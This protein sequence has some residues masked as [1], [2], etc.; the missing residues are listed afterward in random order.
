MKEDTNIIKKEKADRHENQNIHDFNPSQFTTDDDIDKLKK[1]K[2]EA[3][4]RKD[5]DNA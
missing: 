2:E 4:K 1:K 5:G 3:K